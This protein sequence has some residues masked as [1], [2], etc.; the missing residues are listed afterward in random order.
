MRSSVAEIYKPKRTRP[1]LDSR[2]KELDFSESGKGQKKLEHKFHCSRSA[3][4]VPPPMV[5]CTGYC[6]TEVMVITM[7]IQQFGQILST[8]SIRSVFVTPS[9]QYSFSSVGI[10]IPWQHNMQHSLQV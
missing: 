6:T 4:P 5:N 1:Q 7:K 8:A 3:G 9:T 2:I 10:V